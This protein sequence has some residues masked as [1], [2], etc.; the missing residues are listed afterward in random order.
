MEAL[1]WEAGNIWPSDKIAYCPLNGV[2][3]PFIGA[4]FVGAD[5]TKGGI[6]AITSDDKVLGYYP[7]YEE[8][9]E[10]CES[11]FATHGWVRGQ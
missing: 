11:Y 9:M 6:A 10:A 5:P 4:Y 8:A 2:D 7:T 3:K 1:K